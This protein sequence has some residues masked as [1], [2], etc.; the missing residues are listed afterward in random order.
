MHSEQPQKIACQQVLA[1]DNS[2]FSIQ[3]IDL[4]PELAADLTPARV[5][6][7]YMA[8]IKRMTLGLIQPGESP[9][10]VAF[11]L[12]GKFPLLCF[13]PPVPESAGLA[14]R[15]CGGLLVQK[16]QCDRGELLFQ[17]EPLPDGLVR[18]SLRLSDYCPLLLGSQRP[19]AIRR[20]L[21][22][23]TQA[24][25]HRL[26]TIRFLA[27]L[28]RELGGTASKVETV[29]VQVREGQYT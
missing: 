14:I 28:Y 5:L 16:A 10:G 29:P 9:E 26:V 17:C 12:L 21:Y 3:W 27:L 6:Q 4:T 7:L 18:V 25:L 19:S 11:R 13:L 24:A 1:E 23:L 15:I 20:W 22:R 8:A 2:V